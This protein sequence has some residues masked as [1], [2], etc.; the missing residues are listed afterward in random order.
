MQL[1]SMPGFAAPHGQ[2]LLLRQAALALPAA[3]SCQ[4]QRQ[5]V[6][7][8]PPATVPPLLAAVRGG[9]TVPAQATTR[10]SCSQAATSGELSLQAASLKGMQ[11]RSTARGAPHSRPLQLQR[12]LQAQQLPASCLQLRA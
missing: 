8:R 11:Q 5:Q 1:R 7:A 3:A 2:Q 4:Q 12:V 9:R 10:C 6:A